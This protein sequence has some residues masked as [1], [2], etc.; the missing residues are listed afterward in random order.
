MIH[1][2]FVRA[3]G[4]LL[5]MGALLWPSIAR[6]EP[7]ARIW[8]STA[9]AT[10]S[11]TL[12]RQ[13]G[14]R[15]VL[16]QED[17]NRVAIQFRELSAADQV[18]LR[19]QAEPVRPAGAAPDAEGER[20]DEPV[21]RR[22][23][24]PEREPEV[25]RALH[26]QFRPLFNRFGSDSRT[27]VRIL[28]GPSEIKM[29]RDQAAGREWLAASGDYRFKIT[30]EDGVDVSV[31]QIVRRIEQL[32]QPYVRGLQV[33][34]E[35][36]RNGLAVY[37]NIGGAAAHGGK[38]YINIVPGAD[39]RVIAHE[40]GHVLEQVAT[41]KDPRTLE[42]WAEAA[43]SDAISVSRYGDTVTHEDQAEFA[44]VYAICLD[45]GGNHLDRLKALSPAR[46]ALWEGM[47]YER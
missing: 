31:E 47:L 46:F 41:E 18:W 17:G 2:R 12:V 14:N 9:G 10:V 25:Q 13:E 28:S 43:R 40:M 4:G 44:L 11:A 24:A 35:G 29:N 21:L 5:L 45:A 33:V 6:P 22:P 16:E 36:T 32:P 26:D 37:R 7:V 34:S 30:I 38:E 20:Q 42:K 15:V 27:R 3:A 8:T 1:N 23:V 39:A 19:E